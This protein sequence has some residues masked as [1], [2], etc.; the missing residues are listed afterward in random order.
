MYYDAEG[1]DPDGRIVFRF[2]QRF[3]SLPPGRYIGSVRTYPYKERT[4]AL[5]FNITHDL[6]RDALPKDIVLPLGYQSE[7][8]YFEPD[9]CLPPPE[10]PQCCILARFDIDLGPACHEHIIDQAVANYT[11]TACEEE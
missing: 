7:G 3:W 11:I 6:S 8:C 4:W 1:I 2:D 9:C 5:P 10:I